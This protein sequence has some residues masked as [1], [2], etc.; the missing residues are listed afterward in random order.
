MRETRAVVILLAII[1]LFILGVV[2]HEL[3]SVLLPFVIAL[4]LAFVFKPL[5]L[6][7]ERHRVP[8]VLS[9]LIVVAI[10]GGILSL[11]SLMVYSS[12]DSFLGNLPTYQAR[13]A[14]LNKRVTESVAWIVQR[15]GGDPKKVN[16]AGMLEISTVTSVAATSLSS[17]ISILSNGF[18]VL[19]FL[20]FLLAGAGELNGKIK[21][22]LTSDHADRVSSIISNID[23]QVRQ[24]L[25]TKSIVSL[26][27]GATTTAILLL[28]GV[29][30][31]LLWG[32]L[33]FLLNFV[34]NV[35]SLVATVFPVVIALLQFDS[36]TTPLLLL[37]VLV[38]THNIIGN[39]IEPKLMQF[40][41]NLSPVLILVML[42]FWGWLWGIWG[43]ILAIPVTSTI[44]I[45]CENV[46]TL[47]P[48]AVLMSG[49]IPAAEAEPKKRLRRKRV[50]R[51]EK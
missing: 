32:L 25:V 38:V 9:L 34:P 44:K 8:T 22:A 5:V 31:A 1:V 36:F 49:T 39:V 37:L 35:G 21:R 13:L 4:F 45:V 41:L 33:A 26:L 47:K 6:W 30:F 7:L 51:E 27:I 23:K 19:L 29:D 3:S 12:V 42:I 46:D 43:M 2:L 28:F 40:S 14:A 10:V 16:L 11:I 48:V 24:Y 50:V 18:L 15:A 17:L 20:L